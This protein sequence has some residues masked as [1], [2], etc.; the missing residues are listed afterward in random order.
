MGRAKLGSW[1]V[2]SQRVWGAFAHGYWEESLEVRIQQLAWGSS[3]RR[4]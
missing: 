3:G 4:R 2:Q 1:F